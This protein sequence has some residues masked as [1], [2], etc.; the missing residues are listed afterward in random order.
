MLIFWKERLV[1]LANT[2]TGST[3]IESALE[4]LAHVAIRRPPVLKHM[5]AAAYLRHFKPFLEKTSGGPFTTVALV[6]E[7]V[8]WLGSW[9]RY[10]Q[11]AELGVP[12]N[13]TAHLDFEHFA[14]AYLSERP[15]AFA[16]V[17]SQARLLGNGSGE[18]LVD[19][20]FRYENLDGFV[21][22]LEDRLDCE[23]T[24]PRMNVSPKAPME[25][26]GAT[27]DR[28][29]AHFAPDYAIWNGLG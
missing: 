7:P 23:I 10:R 6:R 16:A 1:F 25:L 11:R 4:Q 26:Q 19:R 15:P 28:L 5:R 27:R 17:G 13:S 21:H 24:L 14:A 22:F 2:K 18:P 8:D 29:R 20:L 12:E 3:S 9:F